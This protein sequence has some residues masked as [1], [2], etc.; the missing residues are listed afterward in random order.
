MK[1]QDKQDNNT[2]K[3]VVYLTEVKTSG[4]NFFSD[5]KPVLN[6]VSKKNASDVPGYSHQDENNNCYVYPEYVR[7]RG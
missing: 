5:N 3:A 6:R 2:A 4:D 1:K 7:I